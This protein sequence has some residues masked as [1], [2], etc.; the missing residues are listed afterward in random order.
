MTDALRR[1]YA[2]EATDDVAS[3]DLGNDYPR[4]AVA[5]RQI[6]EA[7]ENPSKRHEVLRAFGIRNEQHFYQV[8]ETVNRFIAGVRIENAMT[9]DQA[10]FHEVCREYG[11]EN[12]AKLER[13]VGTARRYAPEPEQRAKFGFD[14]GN[15]TQL[16]MNALTQYEMQKVQSRAQGELAGELAPINGVTMQDWARAQAQLAA[17]KALTGVLSTLHL[18]RAIWDSVSAEWMARMSRDTTATIATVYGQAFSAAAGASDVGAT[19]NQGP[20][21]SLEQWVEIMEA[22]SAS[23]NQ[24]GDANQVLAKYGLNALAWSNAGAWWSTHFS[25]NAMK[26]DGELQRRFSELSNRYKQKFAQPSRDGDVRF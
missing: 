7:W 23:A 6:E 2:L 16:E 14:L 5:R 20:P 12:Q 24:G 25:Q 18:E 4:W 13:L 21:I 10:A 19:D 22:Q 8:S 9:T 11:V 3:F 17:G 26:N 1:D 15:I